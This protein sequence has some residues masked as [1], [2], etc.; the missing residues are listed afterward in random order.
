MRL[1]AGR[2]RQDRPD[3]ARRQQGAA[4]A[5]ADLAGGTVRAHQPRADSHRSRPVRAALRALDPGGHQQAAVRTGCHCQRRGRPPGHRHHHGRRAAADRC[6][7]APVAPAAAHV[8][9]NSGRHQRDLAGPDRTRAVGR[10]HLPVVGRPQSRAVRIHRHQA[11]VTGGDCQRA[12]YGDGRGRRGT[13]RIAGQP[14][15]GL[16][17]AHAD[18]PAAGTRIPRSRIEFPAA[19]DRNHLGAGHADAAEP[20]HGSGCAGV[21]RRRQL[22]LPQRLGGH[23]GPGAEVTQ[24]TV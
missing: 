3:P 16:S 6:R 1:A 9:G 7:H 20:Q 5:G 15:G 11:R 17:R 14:L 12:P 19:S 23:A 8:G 18:A 10:G 22:L 2:R 13:A 4:R 21:R 24:R